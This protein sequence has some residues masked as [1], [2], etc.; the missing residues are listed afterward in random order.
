MVARWP[1]LSASRLE[2]IEASDGLWP[3][4]TDELRVVISL[5]VV[6]FFSTAWFAVLA[7]VV[8]PALGVEA[9]AADEFEVDE[10]GVV[11]AG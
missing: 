8:V 11:L 6:C 9:V 4:A 1:Q 7:G 10:T 5:S 3:M 2:N